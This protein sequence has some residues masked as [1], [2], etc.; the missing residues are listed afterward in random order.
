MT[1]DTHADPE[2]QAD[3]NVQPG[4]LHNLPPQA[5]Q[6]KNAPDW[7]SGSSKGARRRDDWIAIA[8]FHPGYASLLSRQV[9][10]EKGSTLT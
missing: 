1:A 4:Q 2:W 6:E 5:Q 10:R 7:S 3:A 8:N 9:Y